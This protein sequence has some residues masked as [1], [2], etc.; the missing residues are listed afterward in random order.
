M[1]P[2]SNAFQT[3]VLAMASFERT[4]MSG[5]LGSCGW[6]MAPRANSA[7]GV[8]KSFH[9]AKPQCSSFGSCSYCSMPTVRRASAHF[10]PEGE[11][12]RT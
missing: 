12:L 3:A 11:S 8:K 10:Q 9:A 2:A 1:Y 7:I 5:A 6:G 4:S